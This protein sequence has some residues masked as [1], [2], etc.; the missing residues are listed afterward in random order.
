MQ[1]AETI[2]ALATP[3]GAGAVAMVRISGPQALV[4]ADK[5]FRG[6]QTA[7]KWRPGALCAGKL[8]ATAR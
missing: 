1:E 2:A 3:V 5:A 8:S 7:G 4:V 6:K